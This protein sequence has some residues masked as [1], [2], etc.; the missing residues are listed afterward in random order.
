V[1]DSFEV[2][3]E[4][5][6]ADCNVGEF[7]HCLRQTIWNVAVREHVDFGNEQ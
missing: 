7:C 6:V 4:G 5:H 3:G 2:D 1:E